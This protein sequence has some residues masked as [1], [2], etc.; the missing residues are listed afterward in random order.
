MEQFGSGC[1]DKLCLSALL[2]AVNI[3][4]GTRWLHP[5]FLVN[6]GKQQQLKGSFIHSVFLLAFSSVSFPVLHCIVESLWLILFVLSLKCILGADAILRQ[7]QKAGSHPQAETPGLSCVV[8]AV[9]AYCRMM[10]NVHKQYKNTVSNPL[11]FYLTLIYDSV[12]V[13][14]HVNIITIWP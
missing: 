10:H 6:I 2:A 4:C 8:R 1:T 5:S 9:I 3:C 14:L 12:Q 13:M 11:I 7:E